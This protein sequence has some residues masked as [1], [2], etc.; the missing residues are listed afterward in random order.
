[1]RKVWR[2]T[3]PPYAT[4]TTL[5]ANS[6]E[7]AFLERPRPAVAIFGDS[8]ATPA[9]GQSRPSHRVAPRTG[10]P[11]A[12]STK[13]PRRAW[14]SHGLPALACIHPARGATRPTRHPV[15]GSYMAEAELRHEMAEGVVF[16]GFEE[17]GRDRAPSAVHP[18]SVP[19]PSNA[20]RPTV[21]RGDSPPSRTASEH[22]PAAVRPPE[23]RRPRP[24]VA[25]WAIRS[26]ENHGFRLVSPEEKDRLLR[27]YWS[28]PPRQI[29]NSVV[30]AQVAGPLRLPSG[31]RSGS[32]LGE[33]GRGHSLGQADRLVHALVPRRRILGSSLR[34][35]G[36]ACPYFRRGLRGRFVAL[37]APNP[38]TA[39]LFPC[40]PI[41]FLSQSSIRA[42]SHLRTRSA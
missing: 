2:R 6:V 37:D 35:G 23:C 18:H 17:P 29:A 19:I 8:P 38:L 16:W 7:G 10:A 36:T 1:M 14:P 41:P 31:L 40:R 30:L 13:S 15:R 11:Q 25:T 5:S 9:C 27:L 24:V 4:P 39:G 22:S 33:G 21:A 3:S 20:V 32:R 26:Y 34:E 42:R 28:V 12:Y